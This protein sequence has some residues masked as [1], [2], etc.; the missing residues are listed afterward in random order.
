MDPAPAV[1]GMAGTAL[2]PG[3]GEALDALPY[4]VVVVGVGSG[5]VLFANRAAVAASLV[6]PSLS[7]SPSSSAAG[8]APGLD[9]AG[10]GWVNGCHPGER[11]APADTP[12]ARAARG[13]EFNGWRVIRHDVTNAGGGGGDAAGARRATYLVSARRTAG[14]GAGAGAAAVVS[15]IDV[16]SMELAEAELR[17]GLHARDEFVSVATHELK[18]P[19]SSIL[20]SLQLLEMIAGRGDTVPSAEVLS[21]V[22]VVRRQGDRLARLIENLLDV[23][24]INNHRLQLDREAVD[25]CEL[26]GECVEHARELARQAG[27]TITLDAACGTCIAYVD[28]VRLEQVVGNLLTNAVKYG[29]GRPIDVR[30]DATAATVV[31]KVADQGI[32]IAPA[33]QGRVFERFERATDGHLRRSLGLGLFIVRS[34]VEAHGGTVRLHSE[35]GRGSTFTVELPRRRLPDREPPAH[36]GGG[37]E[38]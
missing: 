15:F 7:F 34:V 36:A 24:R 26:V 25:V 4:P 11:L 22:S 1:S 14:A 21:A 6:P 28:R 17:Q 33:D 35:V 20:L 5:A 13:E 29:A 10:A 16:T 37:A 9:G 19:L 23:S 12:L 31:L 32:G 18:E 38:P 8:E 27:S 2:P 3:A 30:L